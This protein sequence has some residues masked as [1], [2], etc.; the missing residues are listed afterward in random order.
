MGK[1]KKIRLVPIF[2]CKV[3][4]TLYHPH[5]FG[6][7]AVD[8]G[9]LIEQNAVKKVLAE[10]EVHQCDI[11]KIGIAVCVG[12]DRTERLKEAAQDGAQYAD[13]GALRNA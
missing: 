6:I 8:D 9:N 5:Q 11:D 4:G 12:F 10:S 2:R 7:M 3:C 1:A 13:V